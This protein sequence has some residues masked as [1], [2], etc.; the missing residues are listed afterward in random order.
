MLL[1]SLSILVGFAASAATQSFTGRDEGGNSPSWTGTNL[2]YLQAL[3][4]DDQ[5]SYIKKL[6]KYDVKVIRLW[7]N[8]HEPTCEKGSLRVRSIPRLE[9]TLGQFNDATLDALDWAM[10]KLAKKGIKTLISPHDSNSLLGD[11][12]A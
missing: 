9:E 7:V 5:D 4:D 1:F 3:S 11:Y 8:S 6:V 10:V 12:R 2:Y